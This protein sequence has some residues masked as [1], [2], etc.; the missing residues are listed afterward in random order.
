[1][2]QNVTFCYVFGFFAVDRVIGEGGDWPVVALGAHFGGCGGFGFGMPAL[3]GWG[4]S[5]PD[6]VGAVWAYPC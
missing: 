5:Y 2:L 6:L 1:M 3:D 4:D